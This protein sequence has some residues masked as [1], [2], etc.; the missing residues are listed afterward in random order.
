MY[1][2][3][4]LNDIE[5]VMLFTL[6]KLEEE[7]GTPSLEIGE[8]VVTVFNNGVLILTMEEDENLSTKVILGKPFNMNYN[9]S[10]DN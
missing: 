6:E 9:V 10:M 1:M 7:T 5:N 3:S 2:S 4:M 8:D